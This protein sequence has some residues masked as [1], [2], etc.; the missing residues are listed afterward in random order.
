MLR[1][2]GERWRIVQYN[3]TVTVPNERFAAV[4]AAIEAEPESAPEDA[5]REE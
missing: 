1:Y 2:D 5:P 3:L 4:R